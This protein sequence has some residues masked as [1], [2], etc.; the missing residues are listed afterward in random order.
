MIFHNLKL[1]NSNFKFVK[2]SYANLNQ[3]L[4]GYYINIADVLS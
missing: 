2:W 1:V 4:Y 3:N